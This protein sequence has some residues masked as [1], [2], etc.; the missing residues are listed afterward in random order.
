MTLNSER[1]YDN[2]HGAGPATPASATAA[3]VVHLLFPF[4][5]PELVDL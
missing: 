1:R 3:S 2:C 4:E 5:P